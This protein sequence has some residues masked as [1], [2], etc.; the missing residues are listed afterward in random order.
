MRTQA[1]PIHPV[2]G[3]R[4]DGCTVIRG[5]RDLGKRSILAGL[6]YDESGQD[7]VEYA[8][9]AVFIGMGAVAA[10]SGFAAKLTSV[11]GVLGSTVTGAV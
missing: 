8:L 1:L 9:I 7:L 11:F 5:L 10:I 3:Q 6:L 2:L 4:R